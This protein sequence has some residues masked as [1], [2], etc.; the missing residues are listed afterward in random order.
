MSLRFSRYL[1]KISL[2]GWIGKTYMF[3]YGYGKW[4]R[5]NFE[6]KNIFTYK[7]CNV[8]VILL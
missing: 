1:L 3:E 7:L 8:P 2:V 6:S 5:I 4:K